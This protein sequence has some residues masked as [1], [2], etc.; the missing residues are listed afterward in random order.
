MIEL[1]DWKAIKKRLINEKWAEEFITDITEKLDDFIETYHD[2]PSRITGWF[3]HY[4]CEKCQGRLTFNIENSKE[5]ICSVCGHVNIGETITKVWY[6]MYR[7]R[8][9]SSVYESGIMY[10]LTGDEKYIRHM[11]KV[12]NFYADNYADFVSEPIAKRF[13]GKLQNQHLDDASAVIAMIQGIDMA[14][15]HFSDKELKNYYE[16]LFKPEAEM[17]DF[18]ANRIYNIPVWIKCA[19]AMI[20]VFFNE[21]E[22]IQKGFYSPFGILE[23]LQKGVTEEGMWY[24]GSMHYH[25]YTVHPIACLMYICRRM[26]FDIPEMPYIY[27]TVERMFVYPLKMMFSS[28]RLPNPNDAHPYLDIFNYRTHYEYASVIYENPLFKKVCSLFCKSNQTK[29]TFTRLI[30]NTW[31]NEEYDV[32]FGTVNNPT[33]GTAMLRSGGTEV[34]FKYGTLTHLHR[35]PDVM[36]FEMSFD[37][38]VVSYDIGNGGYASSL[39]VEWQRKTLC[40]NTVTIDQKDQMRMTIPMGI[41]EEY[42]EKNA[43]I[44]VRAKAVYEATDF[45][46]EF[47]VSENRVEDNF[48]VHSWGDYSVDWFFYCEGELIHDYTTE[49][50]ETL[51]GEYLKKPYED[52]NSHIAIKQAGYQHLLDVEKFETDSDWTVSFRLPDKTIIVSMKGEP[53][54]TVHLVNSYTAN[55]EKTRRGLVVR[56][57]AEKTLFET[58]YECIYK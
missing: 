40:H 56:R 25:Y 36:S 10:R 51:A 39:F 9:N 12:L 16:K 19:Q 32:K 35:H 11:K 42:D 58:V 24:E 13:E 54:T 30:F 38:D 57:Q 22:H 31:D 46:R 52:T 3:H 53:G 44:K 55:K 8:A 29:A 43:H 18:F 33:S 14:R 6:N 26:E 49:K 4:N 27:Y 2:E 45:T 28:L 15:E 5:H 50:V 47:K 20:G 48:L 41:T 37:G 21:E 23:Q 34:F 17:F 7:G 1:I